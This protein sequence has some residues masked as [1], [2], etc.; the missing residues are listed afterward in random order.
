[1]SLFLL[2]YG[3]THC[4]VNVTLRKARR[5]QS[6]KLSCLTENEELRRTELSSVC[7]VHSKGKTRV[8]DLPI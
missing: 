7:I 3:F 5:S 4:E 2:R 8:F 6:Y 1:M